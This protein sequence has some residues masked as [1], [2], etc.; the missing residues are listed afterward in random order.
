[1]LAS[2]NECE[3]RLLLGHF[4]AP[5]AHLSFSLSC[6][7]T[8]VRL[9]SQT[10]CRFWVS[11]LQTLPVEHLALAQASDSVVHLVALTYFLSYSFHANYGVKK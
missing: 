8:H 10:E 6:G 1:M 4:W 11:V 2:G 5:S 7:W 3:G 9:S